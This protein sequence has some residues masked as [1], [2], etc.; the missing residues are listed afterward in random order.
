MANPWLIGLGVLAVGV[1]GMMLMGHKS[2]TSAPDRMPDLN[3]AIRGKPVPVTFGTNRVYAQVTWTNNYQAVSQSGGKK[4]GKGG[5]SGGG[6]AAK[7]GNSGSGYIYKWDMMFQ[8]GIMD[9]P[10]MIIHG[11]IGGDRI[12]DRIISDLTSG[13]SQAWRAIIA[14]QD[15]TPALKIATLQYDES[16]FGQGFDTGDTNIVDWPYFNGVIG[17]DMAF[18]SNA[19]VGFRQLVLGQSPAVPQLSFEFAPADVSL[20]YA[21]TGK[22]ISAMDTPAPRN[23]KYT[24]PFAT[25]SSA[26]KY[27]VL[28]STSGVTTWNVQTGVDWSISWATMQTN[29]RTLSGLG[30]ATFSSGQVVPVPGTEYVYVFCN[31]L[32]TGDGGYIIQCYHVEIDGSLTFVNAGLLTEAF[33]P[34]GGNLG[35]IMAV[36]INIQNEV[37]VAGN[38][39]QF[40]SSQP[41]HMMILPQLSTFLSHLVPT[42]AFSQAV[43]G[44]HITLTTY[45]DNITLPGKLGFINDGTTILIYW[46]P[47]DMDYVHA[48]PGQVPYLDTQLSLFPSGSLDDGLLIASTIFSDYAGTVTTTDLGIDNHM[49]IDQ[50][51]NDVIPYSDAVADR[52]VDDDYEAPQQYGSYITASRGYTAD[53]FKAG[54]RFGVRDPASAHVIMS[55]LISGDYFTSADH[56]GSDPSRD[57]HAQIDTATRELI[58]TARVSGGFGTYVNGT[59]GLPSEA[60]ADV[61]PAYVIYRILTSEVFGF[62]TAAAFGYSITVDRIDTT[63]YLLAHQYCVDQG[64]FIS[65]TYDNQQNML[66]VIKELLDLYNG[67]LTIDAGIIKFGYV[68]GSVVP[69]RTIDNDHLVPEEPG[70]PPVQ[71]TKAALEDGFNKVLFNYLDR[72]I[73]YDQ[74]Q[75]GVE[76]PVDIDINGPRIKTYDTKFVMN[77][78]V[79]MTIA[80]RALWGNL[81]GTD[82]YAFQLGWKDADLAVGD[83]I[84]LVDSFDDIL[85]SGV[86]CRLT[87]WA[88]RKRGVFTVEA[89]REFPYILQDSA[90]F[91]QTTSMDTG[92]SSLVST[93]TPMQMQ[94]AYELPREFQGAKAHVYFGYAQASRVM[95]AKLYLSTGGSYVEAADVQPNVLAGRIAQALPQRTKGYV[96]E[97]LEFYLHTSSFD[98]STITFCQTLAMDDVPASDRAVGAGIFIVGS[99]A[100]SVENLTLLGQNHYRAKYAYRG[101]GGSP[102]AAHTSG[103]FFHRHGAGIFAQE[104]TT[105][106]IGTTFSYKIAGY[107]FAG[108]VY[109]VSSITAQSYEIKGDFWLPRQQPVTQVYVDSAVSWPNSSPFLGSYLGTVSGGCNVTLR[110]SFADNAEG[111][112]AGGYGGSTYGHFTM[113]D[114]TAWRIDIASSN[115][116]KVSSFVVNT[117]AFTYN[118]AQNSAD[119]SG[120]GHS[121]IYT[122]TPYNNYGDGPV[123]DVRSLSLN[124]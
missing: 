13:G 99:E 70:K 15:A 57:V 46:G 114:S 4:G 5:G 112:G 115:G 67:F 16:F 101:W 107:N 90:D 91:T 103:D 118:R 29:V 116:V 35:T 117:N 32:D 58:V 14:I 113:S 88:P 82:T 55:G 47:T 9:R 72:A 12:D 68:D 33:G 52:H 97:G 26:A 28:A 24:F 37:L 71:T 123:N 80:K 65:V 1:V 77:G 119:F 48:N 34:F 21:P 11:W 10:S 121:L 63:S 96:E 49:F 110:W 94:T 109:D 75:V 66:D 124:W 111:Y 79:A 17:Y 19:W 93:P 53:H 23:N 44:R 36:G 84:T 8:Y 56:A 74:N 41:L 61:T 81:Y 120:F 31:P 73:D 104:I 105:D 95:G 38:S 30:S 92:F 122:V 54:I 25:D 7:G 89:R 102:I 20:V 59:F 64:I 39:Q 78:S 42:P 62:A 2:T 18:P 3:T 43:G 50:A 76:D 51:G 83:Q 86:I 108:Q 100:I 45:G 98:A 27:N 106:K 6:G 69:V 22:F 60:G 40:A 87:K 85:K